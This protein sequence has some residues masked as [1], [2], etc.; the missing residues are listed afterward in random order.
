MPAVS[1]INPINSNTPNRSGVLTVSG[2][3][4]AYQQ[5]D[6]TTFNSSG[7]IKTN[8]LHSDK[9]KGDITLE[10]NSAIHISESA[11]LTSA[12]G[13]TIHF[14]GPVT[15]G[16]SIEEYQQQNDHH[17]LSSMAY[18]ENFLNGIHRDDH[19]KGL[20]SHKIIDYNCHA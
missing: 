13:A 17:T 18:V 14:K 19:V 7:T 16:L 11:S 6:T 8:I 4:A 12:S 3:S 1:S 15:T 20:A 5:I 9:L 2:H 10:G